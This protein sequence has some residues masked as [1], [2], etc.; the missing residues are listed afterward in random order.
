MTMYSNDVTAKIVSFEINLHLKR[1]NEAVNNTFLRNL[2]Y[3]DLGERESGIKRRFR[4]KT[5]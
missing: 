3:K 1:K 2:R 4:I 5:T